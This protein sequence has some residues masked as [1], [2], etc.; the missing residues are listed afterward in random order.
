[1]N[2]VVIDKPGGPEALRYS[3]DFDVPE[4]E[5]NEVL[6]K[7]SYSGVNYIDTY[8]RSGLY[9][10]PQLPLVL[11]YEGAG[12][13]ASVGSSNPLGFKEGDKVVWMNQSRAPSAS[14][15]NASDNQQAHTHPTASSQPRNWSRSPTASP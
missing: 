14:H 6:V 9:P 7:T 12:E 8:F 1:M 4:P 2:A 15:L 11:G 10:A 3:E 13:V 5:D